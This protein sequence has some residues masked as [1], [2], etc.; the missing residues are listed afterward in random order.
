MS[1]NLK[2]LGTCDASTTRQGEFE[3]CDKV[4]V[5]VKIFDD[6]GDIHTYPVC[7]YHARGKMMSLL[8]LIEL[9]KGETNE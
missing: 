7:A 1:L 2:A 9:I 6:E 4:A 5:A 3:A 8:E